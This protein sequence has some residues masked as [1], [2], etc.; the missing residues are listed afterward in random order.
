MM[1]LEG[2]GILLA[3]GAVLKG[4]GRRRLRVELPASNALGAGDGPPQSSPPRKVR[5]RD[6]E[7]DVD[8]RGAPLRL[9]LVAH[10]AG[11]ES[12]PVGSCFSLGVLS[13][14]AMS[15]G[16]VGGEWRVGL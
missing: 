4:L 7:N 1:N 11:A 16:S 12:A 8:L 3:N 6:F 14:R 13:A 9:T 10:P 5:G 2:Q 15:D